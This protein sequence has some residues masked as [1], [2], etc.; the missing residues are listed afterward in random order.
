MLKRLHHVAMVVPD[1]KA[2]SSFYSDVLGADVSDAFA[3]SE[4]GVS[5]VTVQ[6]SN[7]LIELLHPLGADSPIQKFLEK[8]PSGAMHHLCFEVDDVELASQ[9]LQEQGVRVLN[10]GIPKIGMESV[11][12]IF[13]HPKDT[14]GSLIE[15]QNII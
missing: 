2:A 7:V 9:K 10:D 15:F 1:L 12:V 11:P 14:M 3:L 6:L 8:H 13:I 4:H 5:I